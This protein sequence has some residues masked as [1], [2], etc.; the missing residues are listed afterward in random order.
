MDV[1]TSEI[2]WALNNEI[3]QVT[4]SWSTFIPCGFNFPLFYKLDT[5]R[6]NVNILNKP[7]H[8]DMFSCS[9]SVFDCQN[10]FTNAAHS[11]LIH[12]SSMLYNRSNRQPCWLKHPLPLSLSL[13]LCLSTHLSSSLLSTFE[14]GKDWDEEVYLAMNDL[15]YLNFCSLKF[16]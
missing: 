7:W 10:P 12:L 4:S 15:I 13:S 16:I 2:C 9:T 11:N 3:K 6:G 1:L 8:G 14:L 5:D